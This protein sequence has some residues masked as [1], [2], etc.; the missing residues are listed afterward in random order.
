MKAKDIMTREV[1]TVH[2]HATIKDIAQTLIDHKISGVPV[3]DD[4]GT[5]LGIVSEG[6][7]LHKETIPRIPDFFNILGAI[8]YYNGIERYN[9]DFKKLIGEQADAIMTEKVVTAAADTE[10]DEI[11]QKMLQHRVKRIPIVEG[12]R[13]VGLISRADII[14]LLLH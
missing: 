1:I 14:K 6:D 3:V 4:D 5:L 13:L 8:I 2:K 7:L 11:A 10:V 12:K 9:E